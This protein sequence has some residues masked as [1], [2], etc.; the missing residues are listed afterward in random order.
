MKTKRL[1]EVDISEGT[2][3]YLALDILYN[4]YKI[5]A[6]F[7]EKP[8]AFTR[9]EFRKTLEF[10]D[11]FEDMLDPAYELIKRILEKKIG[12]AIEILESHKEDFE[13]DM[14]LSFLDNVE[15]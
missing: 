6:Q 13:F 11:D 3:M 2:V 9:K 12:D 14:D 1:V 8:H 7:E 10:K 4:V 15:I 5:E